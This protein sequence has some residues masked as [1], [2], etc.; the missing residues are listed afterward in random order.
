MGNNSWMDPAFFWRHLVP[1]NVGNIMFGCYF[2]NIGFGPKQVNGLAICS[3][4]QLRDYFIRN[5][6]EKLVPLN[7][8]FA[9][10]NLKNR[11]ENRP[12]CFQTLT[13]LVQSGVHPPDFPRISHG[14]PKDFSWISHPP[15]LLE[16][17]VWPRERP[18]N[19]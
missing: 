9:P 15:P 12:T 16:F 18:T 10:Q 13:L 11:K 1:H 17:S 2:L 4:N 5:R 14:F 8:N 3:K 6:L 7:W 19:L